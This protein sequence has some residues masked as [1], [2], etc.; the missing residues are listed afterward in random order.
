M[1]C[2]VK[3]RSVFLRLWQRLYRISHRVSDGLYQVTFERFLWVVLAAMSYLV[4]GALLYYK[5]M[6][7]TLNCLF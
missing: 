5:I 7:A 2:P 6:P 1:K 4:V 3:K